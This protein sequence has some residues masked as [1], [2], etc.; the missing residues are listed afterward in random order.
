MTNKQRQSGAVSLFIV[1]FSALLI[2][3]IVTAFV[4]IM[5]QDQQQ[6]TTTDLAKSAMDSA[7]AGVEDVKR[8]LVEYYKIKDTCPPSGNVRCDTLKNV[9]VAADDNQNNFDANG[10]TK[11]CDVTHR[12]GITAED[13]EVPVK[14]NDKDTALDQAYTCVKVLM[15]PD[16]YLGT[17][18]S[19]VIHLKSKNNAEFDQ[20]KIQWYVQQDDLPLDLP[21]ETGSSYVLPDV[22]P[23][24]RPQVLRAQLLQYGDDFA[25]TDFDGTAGNNN[26]HNSTLFLVPS[27]LQGANFGSFSTDFRKSSTSS[28][29]QRV[30]CKTPPARGGYACEVTLD[31]PSLGDAGT[32][33]NAYLKIDQLYASGNK[34]FLVTMLKSGSPDPVKLSDVQVVVDSTGRAND[35]FKRIRSRVDIAS[36]VPAPGAAVDVTRS[37]CKEFMVT[38]SA[39]YSGEHPN[40]CPKIPVATT[41]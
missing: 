22:W 2:V 38:E 24:K 16:D 27:S 35:I 36:G 26:P 20:V 13:G 39:A 12:A 14:T 19:Q 7:Q 18:D 10:W 6:A 21:P 31:L 30:E 17:K 25:V 3:T 33:R 40:E 4:R 9:L 1:I 41:P 29:L 28:S 37:F 11:G 32:P 15:N 8:A 5:L 23:A 34:N